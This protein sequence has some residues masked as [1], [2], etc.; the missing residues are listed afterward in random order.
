VYA[1]SARERHEGRTGEITG[2]ALGL[3]LEYAGH[4]ASEGARIVI[5]V[6]PADQTRQLVQDEGPR[7][8]SCRFVC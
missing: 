3:G 6:A 4:P 5:D 7:P 1:R 2:A 8:S